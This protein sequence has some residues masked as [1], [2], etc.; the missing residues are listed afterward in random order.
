MIRV[1]RQSP[2]AGCETDYL[3]GGKKE[4]V[5]CFVKGSRNREGGARGKKKKKVQ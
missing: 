2:R 4:V 3:V 5:V 1:D